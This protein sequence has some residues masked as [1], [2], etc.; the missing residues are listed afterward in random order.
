MSKRFTDTEKWTGRPWFRKLSPA[1]KLLWLYMLDTCDL[2]GVIQLDVDLAAF[3][4]GTPITTETLTEMGKQ[5]M[6]IDGGKLWVTDFVSFQ[7]GELKE[8][9]RPHNAVIRC[10]KGYRKGSN[11]LFNLYSKGYKTKTRT[12][13]KTS[14]EEGGAGEGTQED[15]KPEPLS[16]PFIPAN[17][18]KTELETRLATWCRKQY[19]WGETR[20]WAEKMIAMLREIAT[21][22]DL[23]QEAKD[24]GEAR[25]CGWTYGRNDLATLLNNWDCEV[26][27]AREFLG[28]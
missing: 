25:K 2:A 4:I 16:S 19:R 17:F 8:S 15:A 10:L 13:T 7:Y 27:R 18:C 28:E 20:K 22:D 11:T 3:V 26:D 1:G 12:K 9:C 24:I 6:E 21:R 14:E 23:P 5:V